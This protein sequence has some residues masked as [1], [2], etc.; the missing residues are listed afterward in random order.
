M[1]AP[2]LYFAR[3][4]AE[5]FTHSCSVR[6]I[7]SLRLE[8][9]SG[10]FRELCN[11]MELQHELLIL[12]YKP[13]FHYDNSFWLLYMGVDHGGQGDKYP[14]IWRRVT[15]RQIVL[16][17]FRHIGTK[18]SVLWPSNY[19]KIRF[20]PGLCRWGSSRR[21]PRLPSRLERRHPSP[22]PIPLGTDPPSA[23]AMRPQKSS[24]IYAYT[25]VHCCTQKNFKLCNK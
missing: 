9:S 11:V 17:R 25:A 18:M 24:Q 10:D 14:R 4:F 8:K 23:L 6:T 22:Y 7:L 13:Q 3:H 20:R 21:S 15:L 1:L 12:S 2:S 16:L 19:A 5:R